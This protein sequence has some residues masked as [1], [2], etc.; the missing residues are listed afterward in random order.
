LARLSRSLLRSAARCQRRP[1]FAAN[2]RKL[3]ILTL[4][5]EYTSEGL[6]LHVGYSLP[7]EAVSEILRQVAAKRGAPDYIRSD[8]GPKFVAQHLQEWLAQAGIATRH[9]APGCPWQN[10]IEESF[11]GRLRD[12]RLKVEIFYHAPHAQIVLDGWRRHYNE[13]RP[14][15]SLRWSYFRGQLC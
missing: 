1:R 8:N 9:I 14:H 5:D 4:E 3:K 7:S 12:E 10:G 11:N 2:G 6:A 13:A 15:S